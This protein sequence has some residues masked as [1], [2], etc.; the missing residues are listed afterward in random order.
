M[1]LRNCLGMIMSVSTLIILSGAATPSKTVN[2]SMGLSIPQSRRAC[3]SQYPCGSL[4]REW[5][6]R[7]RLSLR[8][9]LLDGVHIVVGEAEMVADLVYQHMADDGSERLVVPAPVV[10]DRPAV[11]PD[12]VGHLDRGA[13]VPERQAD[14][15][16]QAEQ[17][18]LAFGPHL[19]QH[20]VGREIL[21]PDDQVLAQGA[22][23]RRQAAE[24]LDRDDLDLVQRG[25]L[26]PPPL[27]RIGKC[28][29]GHGVV[30]STCGG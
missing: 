28:M 1:V 18:E 11:E 30:V 15:L 20:L 24:C 4:Y 22:E 14:A 16:E 5:R 9:A 25:R 17:V 26:E 12:H 19:V 29:I 13:L 6:P 2:L 10:E 23:F 7:G 27:E 21:D 8:N 3:L